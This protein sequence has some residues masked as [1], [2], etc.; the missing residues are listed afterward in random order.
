MAVTAHGLAKA[1]EILAGQFTLAATNVPYLAGDKQSATLCEFCEG[2]F[3]ASK[4]N[5]AYVSMER[6]IAALIPVGTIA[7]VR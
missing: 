5:L 2:S 7:T 3:Q 1:A 4:R 6:M